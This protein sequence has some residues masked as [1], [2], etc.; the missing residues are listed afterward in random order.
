M[1]GMEM[2]ATQRG[3]TAPNLDYDHSSSREDSTYKDNQTT[4]SEEIYQ[5]KEGLIE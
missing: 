1:E 4:K 5:D 3:H 2:L